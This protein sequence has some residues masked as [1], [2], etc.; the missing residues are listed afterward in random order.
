VVG[1]TDEVEVELFGVDGEV[2][3]LLG[4]ELLG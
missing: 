4:P 1:Y 2:E 3:E